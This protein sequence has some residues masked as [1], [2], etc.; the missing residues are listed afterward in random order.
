MFEDCVR[1][2]ASI[3]VVEGF[4]RSIP[5]ALRLA[6]SLATAALVNPLFAPSHRLAKALYSWLT[7]TVLLIG[8]F[9]MLASAM[10]MHRIEELVELGR[11][12][13]PS[14]YSWEGEVIAYRGRAQV[15]TFSGIAKR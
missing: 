12:V 2:G 13:E 14:R 11:S 5:S 3:F 8:A 9:D 4:D 10:R 1:T 7:P 15:L 6:P